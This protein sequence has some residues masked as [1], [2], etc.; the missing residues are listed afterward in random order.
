[1]PS[2]NLTNRNILIT[3]G[4]LVAIGVL[5]T[6]GFLDSEFADRI[7]FLLTG[8][9]IGFAAGARVTPKE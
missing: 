6:Q 5:V 4:V 3:V 8:G 2:P 7:L 1:M 9:G